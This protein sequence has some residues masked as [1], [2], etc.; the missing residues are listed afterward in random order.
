MKILILKPSGL[1]DI[2]HS[3]PVVKG[4]KVVYPKAEVHWLVFNKFYEILLNIKEI[5]KTI[6][7]NR[8]GG[9][10][11]YIRVLKLIRREKYDLAI[12]LQGLLRTAI[13]VYFSKSKRKMA[14]SLL[15][16]FSWLI[17]RPVAKFEPSMHAV[18][19][20]YLIVKKLSNGKIQQTPLSFLPWISLT[21]E[22]IVNAKKL[23]NG[24]FKR[25]LVLFITTSRGRHKVWP[26]SYFSKL[27]NLMIKEFNITPIFLGMSGEEE[28]VSMITRNIAS[29]YVN[30]VGRTNLRMACAVISL[31][32]FVIGN[33][34]GLLHISSAL[35][36][37]TFGIFGPT[38]PRWF[39]PYN[40]KSTFIY[41][42]YE[43]SPCG[44]KP[45]CR[46]YKCM[47]DI[48]VDEVYNAIKEIIPK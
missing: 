29:Y 34:S 14:T 25:P 2:I 24:N 48:T 46:T 4:L 7:W 42:N 5:D 40:S 33:D 8:D 9:W 41:K 31:C 1:G 11:E 15:R 18:D 6:L 47:W 17:E 37:P 36:K 30:L 27:I 26:A 10:A 19:R 16:E 45:N 20:N 44:I 23:L 43:C 12:D 22:E 38:N 21:T 39:S 28:T 13:L 35:D 3:I 32:D